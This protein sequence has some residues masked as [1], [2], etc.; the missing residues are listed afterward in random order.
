MR[1]LIE[2]R[3]VILCLVIGF[4]T[5]VCRGQI[6]GTTSNP[7]QYLAIKK[8]EDNILSKITAQTNYRKKEAGIQAELSGTTAKIRNWEQQY[9]AYLK[10]AS[11][12]AKRT[13]ACCQLYLEGVQTL[14]ALWEVSAAKKINPQGVFATMSM[15]NLYMETAIQ[16]IK[17]FRSLKK[18]CAKGTDKNMLNGAERTQLIWNLER[19]L[20]QLNSKLRRLA[21]SISVFSFEDVWNRAKALKSQ[22]EVMS[23]NLTGH[24]YISDQTEKVTNFQREFDNYLSSFGDMLTLAASIY[25]IYYQVDQTLKNL[26][27]LKY[28]GVSC[29]ANVLAVALS[30]KK[31]N[32]YK[33]VIDDGIQIAADVKQILPL[34][35]SKGKNPKLT[36]HQRIQVI[37]NINNTLV[38]LN[39]KLR[40]MN[41]LIRYTSLLD[42]WYELR[43]TPRGTRSMK[44]I[45][46]DCKRGW[47]NKARTANKM[48]TK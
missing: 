16:F 2:L 46:A 5:A 6:S 26:K 19:E 12:Y 40:R 37:A 20:E 9:N 25:G 31:N 33:D 32:I 23:L 29:P 35:S 14:N 28:V 13:V 17:T 30:Q 1:L 8:G 38:K 43:G 47:I 4:S 11:G 44:A 7:G 10:E 15:N 39:F 41:R 3:A 34:G 21:V 22:D 45:V 48:N 36:E 42:S 27:E 24:M 18:V